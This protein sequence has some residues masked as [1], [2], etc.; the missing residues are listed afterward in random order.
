MVVCASSG[1][2]RVVGKAARCRSDFTG[3]FGAFLKVLRPGPDVDPGYFGHFFQTASY[4]Q[5]VSALAA[6]VNINNLK[7]EHLDDLVL[8]LPSLPE[9]RRI[10]AILDHADALRAKRRQV[11]SSLDSLPQSIF[12][13]MF[14]SADLPRQPLSDLIAEHQIGLDRKSSELGPDRAFD[15]VKMDCIT[16]QG[17][18]DLSPLTRVDASAAELAK[19]ELVDGDLLLNTR[20][21]RELVGK[22]AVYRGSGRLFNNN[23]MR[24]RFNK[25]LL[26]DY[27]HGYL[28][29]KE[30]RRQLD[31]RKSGTTSVFAVYAKSLMTVEIPV[32]PIDAQAEFARLVAAIEALR[33]AAVGA[34]GVSDRLVAALQSR[35][36]GGEL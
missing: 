20:N 14:P 9:Q 23:I 30:G 29:S 10:A 34:V 27:V 33:T 31:A 17:R 19:Y 24:I 6:G 18:L 32:P 11:L 3:G 12:D 7:N 28:W 15:Y 36:F 21:T 25:A 1:S 16:R 8:P 35:A 2:L 22:T 26:P 5:K 4:R 13:Q